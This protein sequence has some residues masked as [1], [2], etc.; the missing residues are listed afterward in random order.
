[1][2]SFKDYTLD[3]VRKLIIK[4]DVETFEKVAPY[5]TDEYFEKKEGRTRLLTWLV[6]SENLLPFLKILVEC[7]L[8]VDKYIVSYDGDLGNLLMSCALNCNQK[9]FDYLIENTA[10]GQKKHIYALDS[11]QANIL[12]FACCEGNVSFI[13]YLIDRF[14]FDINQQDE[15][16][17]L[18]EDMTEKENVIEY[19][20]EHRLFK[21]AQKE[22]AYIETQMQKKENEVIKKV[23]I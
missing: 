17:C 13:K 2:K 3:E 23:K 19:L 4:K 6:G 10:L 15:K 11:T 12:H 1:M 22:K 16:K 8:V 5:L 21:D 20:K 7:N 18:P 14:D 9:T